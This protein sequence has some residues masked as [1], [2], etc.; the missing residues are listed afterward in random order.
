IAVQSGAGGIPDLP[1]ERLGP[2]HHVDG[3][4][5]HLVLVEAHRGVIVCRTVAALSGRAALSRPSAR[6]PTR[7][8]RDAGASPGVVQPEIGYAVIGAEGTDRGPVPRLFVAATRHRYVL[9]AVS[10]VTVMGLFERVLLPDAPP[11]D[12]VHVAV[13]L[14]IGAPL[15][16]GAVNFT[17]S[18]P[19][20][21]R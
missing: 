15:P 10:P 9:P 18:D 20:A 21:G 5:Q 7:G 6:R 16:D 1:A 8:L 19:D 14:V 2:E 12:E 4:R 17:F 3:A 11:S 13:K